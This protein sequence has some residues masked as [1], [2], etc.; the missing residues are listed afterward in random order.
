MYDHE[1]KTSQYTLAQNL[2]DFTSQSNTG[3]ESQGS[4]HIG[5]EGGILVLKIFKWVLYTTLI[6]LSSHWTRGG[7]LI[8]W[9]DM[10]KE[11]TQIYAPAQS[12]QIISQCFLQLKSGRAAVQ[13]AAKLQILWQQMNLSPVC[14][15][16]QNPH[17]CSFSKHLWTG[18]LYVQC[19]ATNLVQSQWS[20]PEW[21]TELRRGSQMSWNEAEMCLN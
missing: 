21:L 4:L 19:K 13:T 12:W 17:Y 2:I 3:K 10:N 15:T 18:V 6:S 20:Y 16:V 9:L 14:T 7:T 5:W 1:Q 8:G 11:D